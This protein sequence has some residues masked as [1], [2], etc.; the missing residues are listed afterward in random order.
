MKTIFYTFILIIAPM[1]ANAELLVER[2]MFNAR[3][4]ENYVCKIH[5]DMKT[6]LVNEGIS[7]GKFNTELSTTEANFKKWLNELK[8]QA[9]DNKFA[10]ESKTYEGYTVRG[11]KRYSL[12]NGK[13]K[14]PFY[15]LQ[16]AIKKNAKG[17]K[18]ATMAKGSLETKVK[19]D[20]S[21]V[22]RVRGQTDGACKKALAKL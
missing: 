14:L 19:N 21:N 13:S 17:K 10:L 20:N 12:Y 5:S 22:N 1:F 8:S 7:V 6:E 18:K 11:F 16:P 2:E 15:S 3:N 4:G 9:K